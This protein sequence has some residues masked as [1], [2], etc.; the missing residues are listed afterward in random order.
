M[1]N[2]TAVS[3]GLARLPAHWL[4]QFAPQSVGVPQERT[5]YSGLKGWGRTRFIIRRGRLLYAPTPPNG[6]VLRRTPILAWALLEALERHPTLPDVSVAFNCEATAQITEH[7]ST[8]S[9]FRLSVLKDA[10]VR[11]PALT[12][13]DKPTYWYPDGPQ[14]QGNYE[15]ATTATSKDGMAALVFSYTTGHTFS[16]V[17]LPDATFYGLPYARIPPWS[18]WLESLNDGRGG[19]SWASKLDKMLWVGTTGVGNGKLGFSSHP[20]R[21]RFA[22]CGPQTFGERLVVHSVAKESVDSLAWKQPPCPASA[23][24][25]G[26]GACVDELPRS[27]ITLREQCKH[28]IIVHLP[29]VSDWLEHFKHQLSCGSLNIYVTEERDASQ[30][31]LRKE[32]EVRPPL[33]PPLFEHFDWWAPLLQAGVHYVHIQIPK[34]QP[35]QVCAA[36]QAA[37]AELDASPGRAQ[38]IAERGQQLARSLTMDK[39]HDY[40]ANVLRGAAAVQRPEVV[41]RHSDAMATSPSVVT[42]R[43]LLRHVSEST[44][45]WIEHLF[46]PWHN[47]SGPRGASVVPKH[48]FSF[49]R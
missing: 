24:K 34:R 1:I 13:R 21:A 45:P 26:A 46:L 35:G 14:P 27:W 25:V 31:D 29:G 43:N 39:V 16:D 7:P 15:K 44:R 42:K 33:V 19:V 38:C 23:P 9:A 49:K 3:V 28:K 48:P 4:R 40:L 10:R 18:Q 22:R 36:L 17:P 6:C 20:L 12:G 2:A 8:P 11:T 32:G 5:T 41:R 47:A 37:L 30:H